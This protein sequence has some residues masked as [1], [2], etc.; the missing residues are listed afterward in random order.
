MDR[1]SNRNL[2]IGVPEQNKSYF[3]TGTAECADRGLRLWSLSV[4]EFRFGTLRPPRGGGG[5]MGY[6]L[7]RR[8]QTS[9]L[10][11]IVFVCLGLY[12]CGV[13]SLFVGVSVSILRVCV[14]VFTC[15]CLFACCVFVRDHV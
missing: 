7:F 9:F 6:R 5:S 10:V 14:C 15:L 8:P 12:D 2:K 11:V 1:K 13:V 3:G 4:L